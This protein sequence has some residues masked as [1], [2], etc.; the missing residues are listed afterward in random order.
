M[1]FKMQMGQPLKDNAPKMAQQSVPIHIQIQK[2]KCQ[3]TKEEYSTEGKTGKL[4]T[5]QANC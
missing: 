1:V 5:E 2:G 3:I 4:M